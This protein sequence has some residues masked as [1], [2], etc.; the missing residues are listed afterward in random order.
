MS[1]D[2]TSCYDLQDWLILNISFCAFKPALFAS[3]FILL[4]CSA[5]SSIRLSKE[6][7]A[8]LDPRLQAVIA[9]EVPESGVRASAPDVAPVSVDADSTRI[10]SV[11][12]YTTEP[13]AI[14][15]AG[16]HVNSVLPRFV[17]VR[18]TAEELIVLA[19]LDAVQSIRLGETLHIHQNEG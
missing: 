15:E 17:T 16:I 9:R 7:L 8:K 6:Q 2:L 12:V 18:V 4:A 1:F 10:Y 19:K 11:I 3:A 5:G 13:D 14:R